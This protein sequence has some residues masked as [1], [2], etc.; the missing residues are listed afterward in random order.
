MRVCNDPNR[1]CKQ[2]GISHDEYEDLGGDAV[3]T[4][5]EAMIF[6]RK[7]SLALSEAVTCQT[8]MGRAKNMLQYLAQNGAVDG[9][10]LGH[11]KCIISGEDWTF[12]LSCTRCDTV[13]IS[14]LRN[15]MPDRQIAQYQMSVAVLSIIPFHIE[16]KKLLD[17]LKK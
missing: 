13:D 2:L 8:L 11:I 4:S 7:Y 16:E 6:S 3:Q 5:T 15:W 9:I 12:G 17:F 1:R 10:V 14:L